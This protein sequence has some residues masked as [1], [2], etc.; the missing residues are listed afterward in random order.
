MPSLLY[1]S[2]AGL[3]GS[4]CTEPILP[5]R[6]LPPSVFSTANYSL[7]KAAGTSPRTLSTSKTRTFGGGT[8]MRHIQGAFSDGLYASEGRDSERAPEAG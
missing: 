7:P 2:V 5:T 3:T 1:T 6:L 4:T 8:Q